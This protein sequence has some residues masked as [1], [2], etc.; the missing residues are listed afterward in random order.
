MDQSQSLSEAWNALA[1]EKTAAAAAATAAASTITDPVQKKETETKAH[2]LDESA[3]SKQVRAQ[4]LPILERGLSLHI[5]DHY[6]KAK[7]PK[8]LYFDEYYQMHG[9]DFSLVCASR[10]AHGFMFQ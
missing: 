6:I 8:S 5:W 2:G 1:T 3:I 10:T 7:L 4:I 9:H